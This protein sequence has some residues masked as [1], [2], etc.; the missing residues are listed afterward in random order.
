[1]LT[2][3][4]KMQEIRIEKLTLNFGAGKDADLLEKGVKLLKMISGRE[5]IKTI[6][7]KRIPDWGVRPGL[8]LG[9]KITL[10]GKEAGELLL[11]LIK[12]KN[13]K[14]KEDSFGPGNFS[15][16]LR[17]YLDVPGLKYDP[18][19]GMLGFEAAVTLGRPGFR[20][21]YRKVM[22]KKI[23]NRHRITIDETKKFAAEKLGVEMG[24]SQ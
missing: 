1:M 9:C 24:E 12:A 16:G 11:R 18:E 17:E 14:L 5:P 8:P 2:K 23:P 7:Q 15:V 21:K 13:N 22:P 10:R 3:M 19:L 6:T 20:I 4:N